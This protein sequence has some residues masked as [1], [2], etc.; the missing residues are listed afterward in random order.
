M[1][2]LF[3][4]L[5]LL[6][7]TALS[8]LSLAQVAGKPI[9]IIVPVSA[10]TAVDTIARMLQPHLAQRLEATVVVENRVGA[11]GSIGIN[12]AAR[13]APDG[14]TILLG[15]SAM[16]MLQLLQ[17]DLPWN[18]VNDFEAVAQLVSVPYG[19]VVTPALPVKNAKELIALAKNSWVSFFMPNNTSRAIIE[20]YNREVASI[21]VLP[22]AREDLQ[23]KGLVINRGGPDQMA[24]LLKRDMVLWTR[25]VGQGRI[26]LDAK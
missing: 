14:N 6:A 21:L 15:P 9:T 3:A 2:R 5:A 12:A 18:A 19:V 13:S 25:V 23:K 20:K 22:D 7:G 4:L 16:A 8:A 1:K 11:S 24:A 10:G 26:N 17:K